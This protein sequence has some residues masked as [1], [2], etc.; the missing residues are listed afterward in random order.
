MQT[1]ITPGAFPL[2][3]YPAWIIPPELW[4]IYALQECISSGKQARLFNYSLRRGITFRVSVGAAALGAACC[5]RTGWCPTKIASHL[6]HELGRGATQSCTK[7][8]AVQI[9]SSCSS[10]LP[11]SPSSR[12]QGSHRPKG[13]W[14]TPWCQ[15]CWELCSKS[16]MVLAK[17]ISWKH[18]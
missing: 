2:H 4:L 14:R 18:N 15:R 16:L 3:N 13:V 9:M 10:P 5:R 8:A 7:K 1:P 11:A 17:M 6:P 12:D